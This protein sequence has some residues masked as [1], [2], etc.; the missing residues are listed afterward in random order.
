[1]NTAFVYSTFNTYRI[2]INFDYS[3]LHNI[4]YALAKNGRTV[5]CFELQK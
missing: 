4:S 5:D 2:T 3:H 1:M